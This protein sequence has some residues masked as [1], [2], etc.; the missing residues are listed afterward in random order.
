MKKSNGMLKMV[1]TVFLMVVI[2]GAVVSMLDTFSE[3]CRNGEVNSS[4]VIAAGTDYVTDTLKINQSIEI[5]IAETQ[6]G[7]ERVASSVSNLLGG[8]SERASNMIDVNKL[9]L[10]DAK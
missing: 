10:V 1:A 6:N 8:C 7:F 3:G 9:L 5:D 4:E 2:G